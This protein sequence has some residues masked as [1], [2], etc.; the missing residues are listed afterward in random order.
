VRDRL[1]QSVK[2]GVVYVAGAGNDSANG[3]GTIPGAYRE[4]IAASALADSDGLKGPKGGPDLCEGMPDDSFA[5]FSNWGKH[6]DVAAPGVCIASTYLGSDVA[7]D[8]GTSYATPFVSGAAA[9]FIVSK[10]GRRLYQS[11]RSPH[12]RVAAVRNALMASEERTHLPWDPDR[13]NE[14]VINVRH[15]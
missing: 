1:C 2:A 9:L 5:S 13:W 10:A 14:G 7:V 11:I 3:A 8:S 4:V 6:I 12:L 15:F